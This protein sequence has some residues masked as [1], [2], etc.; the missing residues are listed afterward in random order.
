MQTISRVDAQRR[1]LKRF[2]TGTACRRGHVAERLVSDSKCVVCERARFLA[3]QA[4]HP[5]KSRAKVRAWLAAHP[6]HKA[7][8]RGR[9]HALGRAP[10]CVPV[11]FDLEQTIPFYTEAR[12]RTRET[13]VSHEVDHILA[14]SLGGLH[15]ASNLQVIT[16]AANLEKAKTERRQR[17]QQRKGRVR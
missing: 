16:E 13:G 3:W 12:R 15:T 7:A 9:L 5:E 17:R 14:L 6:D 10:G 8:A 2:F 11:D 4:A 1:G